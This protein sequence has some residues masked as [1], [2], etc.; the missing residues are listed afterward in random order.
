V[1]SA[2]SPIRPTQHHPGNVFVS[3][4]S[5]LQERGA[6]MRWPTLALVRVNARFFETERLAEIP[7]GGGRRHVV[8]P[9]RAIRIP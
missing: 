4:G 7:G 1:L 6:G 8:T 5:V 2:S 3:G 9:R